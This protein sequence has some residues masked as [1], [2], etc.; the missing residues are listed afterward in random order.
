MHALLSSGM[1]MLMV[2]DTLFKPKAKLSFTENIKKFEIYPKAK[3]V[4][5]RHSISYR[6]EITF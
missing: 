6:I 4:R 5:E 1:I 2:S 3:K